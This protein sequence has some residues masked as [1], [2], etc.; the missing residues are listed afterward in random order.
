MSKFRSTRGDLIDIAG[1]R[2][3]VICEHC[4]RIIINPNAE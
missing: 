4:G 2:K 1:G 3:L